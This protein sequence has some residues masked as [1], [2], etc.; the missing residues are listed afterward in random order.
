[1]NIVAG[2]WVRARWTTPGGRVRVITGEVIA[3]RSRSHGP[4]LRIRHEVSSAT[5]RTFSWAVKECWR[6]SSACER[7]EDPGRSDASEI[8]SALVEAQRARIE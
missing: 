6:P 4:E 8:A 1:M 5:R 7:I 2:D 3:V